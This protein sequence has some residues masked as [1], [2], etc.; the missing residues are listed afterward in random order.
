MKRCVGSHAFSWPDAGALPVAAAVPDD[1]M[2]QY[3]VQRGDR[4]I[5]STVRDGLYVASLKD[6]VWHKMD[7]PADMPTGGSFAEQDGKSPRLAYYSGAGL[8]FPMIPGASKGSL[9][10]SPDDGKTWKLTSLPGNV[11]DV[12]LHP[13][14]AIYAATE[15]DTTVPFPPGG[16][17]ISWTNDKGVAVYPSIHMAVS[18]DGGTTWQ[19]ITPKIPAA[20]GAMGYFSRSRSSRLGVRAK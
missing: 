11:L 10:L 6:K 12:F 3:V 15:T 4:V 5:A 1:A 2:I 9:Y 19:D 13:D 18:R 17:S 20:F 8:E 14:G 16:N 7:V